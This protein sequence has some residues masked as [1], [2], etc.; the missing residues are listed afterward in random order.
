MVDLECVQLAITEA[1]D[2]VGHVGDEFGERG[3]VIGS[4]CLARMLTL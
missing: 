2:G 4:D 1:I 3:A